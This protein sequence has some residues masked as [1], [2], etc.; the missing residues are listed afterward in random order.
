MRILF[1]AN[2]PWCGT[3]YGIQGS[4]LVPRLQAQG[5][6]LAYFAFYGLK[7]GVLKVG[8]TP[9]FPP[10][11]DPWGADILEAHMDAFKADALITLLDVWVTDHFGRMAEKNGWA[12]LPWFP[13]DQTPAPELVLERLEGCTK[14]VVYSHFAKKEMA[15]T[16]FADLVRYVPHG[17]NRKIFKPGSQREAR[18]RLGLDQDRFIVG[19]VAANKGYPDRKAFAPQ[20]LAFSEL[21]KKHPEALLYLHTVI[22]TAHGGL[23][24]LKLAERC[25]IPEDAIAYC[26]QYQR[27]IGM[28]AKAIADTY[29]AIDVLTSASLGEGFGLPI[30]EAQAC[31]TPVVVG[32]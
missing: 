19:M 2:A 10:G 20:F 32:N 5:H 13:I 8:D 1:M 11:L 25:G 16:E 4:H 14:A 3:G 21:R 29:R 30:I 17:V 31:G 9:I 12:W 28:P 15:E 23:N 26:D 6:K 22:T 18:E 24:L 27:T 7:G